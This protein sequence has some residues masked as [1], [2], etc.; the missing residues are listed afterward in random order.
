MTME[1]ARYLP[2]IVDGQV[3]GILSNESLLNF[4]RTIQEI[5]KGIT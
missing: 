5:T 4:L 3:Q 2:V 1:G